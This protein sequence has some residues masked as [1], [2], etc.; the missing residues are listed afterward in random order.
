MGFLAGEHLPWV[1]WW[2]PTPEPEQTWDGFLPDPTTATGRWANPGLTMLS[3]PGPGSALVLL[4][5]QGSGKTTEAHGL[6][7]RLVADG[8]RARL[9]DLGTRLGATRAA[10]ALNDGLAWATNEGP[11]TIVVDGFDQALAFVPDLGDI[12]EE[13]LSLVDM[14]QTGLVVC[15]RA[16]RWPP[17]LG[18][19]LASRYGPGLG[20]LRLSPL[21][22]EDVRRAIQSESLDA[23]R[24]LERVRHTAAG[25]LASRPAT[26]RMMA[27][28]F[29]DGTVADT[30]ARV[31]AAG[32]AALCAEPDP[33]R[34]RPANNQSPVQRVVDVA[35]RVAAV[36]LLA[37][38]TELRPRRRVEPDGPG[39]LSLE[40]VVGPNASMDETATLWDS[41]L[42][43]VTPG[44]RRW[45]H[46]S[47]EEYLCAS[48][49]GRL[50]APTAVRL[51]DGGLGLGVLPRHE[52][53]AGW[54]AELDPDVFDHLLQPSPT[55][56]L[57]PG[58]R[59]QTAARRQ[60]LGRV[61]VTR[62]D[63][64]RLMP[65]QSFDGLA[66]PGAA[67][68]LRPLLGPGTPR[69][70]RFLALRFAAS[71]KVDG[72]EDELT[73]IVD[74]VARTAT[75]W[76]D[77]VAVAEAAVVALA[78]TQ[79]QLVVDMLGEPDLSVDVQGAAIAAL[80][81]AR[82]TLAQMA[83]LVPPDKRKRVAARIVA[84]FRMAVATRATTLGELLPWFAEEST[85]WTD[86]R[87]LSEMATGA[88]YERLAAT[89][90]GADG[91]ED[92]LKVMGFLDGPYRRLEHWRPE[93]SE[94]LGTARRVSVASAL[95]GGHHVLVDAA[96]VDDLRRVGLVD[97]VDGPAWLDQLA[98]ELSAGR[99]GTVA[100]AVSEYLMPLLAMRD[101]LLAVVRDRCRSDERL[102]GLADLFGTA[103]VAAAVEVAEAAAA[104]HARAEEE[105]ASETFSTSRLDAALDTGDVAL[106]LTETR[107][108]R[109]TGSHGSGPRPVDAW[110]VMGKERQGRLAA[111]SVEAL[112]RIVAAP[113]ADDGP[114]DDLVELVAVVHEHDPGM[115][116]R[117][118]PEGLVRLLKMG[119][120]ARHAY[121]VCGL[122]LPLA[123]ARAPEATAGLLLAELERQLRAPGPVFV[124]GWLGTE[125]PETV[126]GPLAERALEAAAAAD[127]HPGDLAG[128]LGLASLLPRLRPAATQTALRYVE[129]AAGSDP[130]GVRRAEA[131]A[132]ALLHPFLLDGAVER[133]LAALEGR[134]DL[135]RAAVGQAG[136]GRSRDALTRLTA[137]D[138][139]RMHRFF[140]TG[141]LAASP[142]AAGEVYSPDAV[143]SLASDAYG[144]LVTR[145]DHD[146]VSALRW[147]GTETADAFV[148]ADA[149]RAALAAAEK[150]ASPLTAEQVLA[151]L[152]R[153]GSR[154]V[155]SRAQLVQLLLDELDAIAVDL[156]ED[157]ALRRALWER[158]REK[159]AWKGTYVPVEE[160][161]VSDFLKAELRRRLG[162]H[163]ALLREVRIQPALSKDSADE[164]DL[165]VVALN[166]EHGTIDVPVEVKC[167][168]NR[169]VIDDIRDQLGHRYLKGPAGKEGVYVVA[170]FAGDR[171][172]S[173][174]TE[175]ISL[176]GR[177]SAEETRDLL[178]KKSRALDVEGVTAHHRV[179][180]VKLSLADASE[181]PVS[182]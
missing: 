1:R 127:V 75:G 38:L 159:T 97:P 13:A 112:A 66:Y 101:D 141:P 61:L 7:E 25:P 24:F 10:Q 86:S 98:A 19:R 182:T 56:L 169:N 96:H 82:S 151:V 77:D 138:V 40:R 143:E 79:P 54:V 27:A 83:V 18:A 31:Y 113:D 121:A 44:A 119:L 180:E 100:T 163:V 103:R 78:A 48:A 32:V 21:L 52:E 92:A 131:A 84:V 41:A 53:L 45:T 58:L 120:A 154:V 90:V 14:R 177:Y 155:R 116:E 160:V 173:G 134:P 55:T 37:G 152:D 156:A 174:D 67:D 47:V 148:L 108:R 36:T 42:L 87:K 109:P 35:G 9:T 123:A 59:G 95:L 122:L 111:M 60:A 175:R 140:S 166:T 20:S 142:R 63:R 176:S 179:I 29:R 107:R 157:R 135:A 153:P 144:E 102:T 26:L 57:G 167:S 126:I 124:V 114:D 129:A 50:E 178:E 139:A 49:L 74:S 147:L 69:H 168:Y 171:W 33:G 125:T 17:D 133:L 89:E 72:L 91:W 6:V 80:Y 161:H 70:L 137:M 110:P 65:W 8:G 172:D 2:N 94:I 146:S 46:R 11:S 118:G 4:G 181:D 34:R 22:E 68:D 12:L 165:L 132:R 28:A 73:E 99:P 51:L 128:L 3:G 16:S 158:Q 104:A 130:A 85:W 117:L 105:A 71:A 81:P 88:A 145:G 150:D 162:N 30:R 15:C 136:Q 106:A 39:E 5:E 76:A 23:D 93:A 149:E 62:L 64:L 164:P 43:E 170:H 115:F